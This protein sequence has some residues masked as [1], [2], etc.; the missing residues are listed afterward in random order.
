M[1]LKLYTLDQKY[2]EALE[3]WCWRRMEISWTDSVTSEE[4]L[5][6]VKEERYILLTVNWRKVTGLV[7]SYVGTAFQNTLLKER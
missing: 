1:V 3:M 6:R 7:T 2:L 5:N 4:V